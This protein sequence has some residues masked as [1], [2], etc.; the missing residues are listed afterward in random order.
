MIYVTH[1]VFN[2]GGTVG[3]AQEQPPL[4]TI[5]H[6]DNSWACNQ[7]FLVVNNSYLV[8]SNC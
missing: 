3:P 1:A 8:K 5:L 4:L 7:L 6:S 2:G